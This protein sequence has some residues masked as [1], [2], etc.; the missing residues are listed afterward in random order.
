MI[1]DDL[2]IADCG[3]TEAQLI[4]IRR[5]L[6]QIP[7]LALQ[8]VQTS[9]TLKAIMHQFKQ[10]HIE[11]ITLPELPTA[12]LVKVHGTNAQ[13]TIGYRT[14][15]DALA[16]SEDN[17]L[18]F[19][20]TNPGKMHACGHDIH[21]TVAL[22]ILSYFANHQP[23]DN[24]I[25]IF[26]PAE[27]N[28][29]GGMR[30]YESGILSGANQI[31]ELYALH[32]NPDLAA[33][34]IGCR[35][36]TLFAGTTEIHAEF[37]GISGH[38]A[39]PHQANDMVVALSQWLVQLQTIVARNVD[40]I[41]GGVVTI[42]NVSAGTA[43]NVIAGSAQAHG[44]IRALQQ[45]TIDLIKERVTAITRG[46]EASFGCQIK[47]TLNQDGY[48]PVVNAPQITARFIN[49][50]SSN[51][52]INYVET[53]PAMTGEDFGYLVAKIPGMMFWLGVDSPAALHSS[54]YLAN[55]A[56]IMAA[57]KTMI[58][59]IESRMKEED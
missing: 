36:G 39:F 47:L 26:Q 12:I 51:P 17:D 56:A 57:V 40:P 55:E 44:T 2:Q 34:T 15:M 9:A 13:R 35:N 22:G 29:A 6:H 21:M 50:V 5:Y 23:S 58:G 20:S 4:D 30:L 28:F 46:I 37:T 16:V 48:F 31:D 25:F 54:K 27:E 43:N 18:S 19:K 33:G 42:G 1:I 59:F 32:T 10:D 38:A 14:D 53:Q 45:P 8:E 49:Y 7:E 52:A 11:I 41:K 24:L 3:L